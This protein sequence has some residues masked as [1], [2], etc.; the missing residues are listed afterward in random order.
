MDKN[1]IFKQAV[2]CKEKLGDEFTELIDYMVGLFEVQSKLHMWPQEY[3]RACHNDIADFCEH[4]LNFECTR[5]FMGSVWKQKY[6]FHKFVVNE[7]SYK[8][9]K[10]VNKYLKA[11]E[12]F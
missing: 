11:Q 12:D 3:I 5:D 1:E 6:S 2:I 9:L 4:C 7:E 10:E 8:L